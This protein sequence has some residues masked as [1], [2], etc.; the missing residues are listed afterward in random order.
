[1]KCE[2]CNIEKEKGYLRMDGTMWQRFITWV[3]G[4]VG[5]FRGVN[6]K[7]VIAIAWKCPTCKKIDLISE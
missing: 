5:N 6:F 7:G 2:K 1:M 3:K 4:E